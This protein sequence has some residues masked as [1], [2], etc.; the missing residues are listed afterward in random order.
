MFVEAVRMHLDSLPAEQTGWLAGLRDRYVGRALTLCTG[1]RRILGRSR[2]WRARSGCHARHSP[3]ASCT[4]RPPPDALPYAVAHAGSGRTA[5]KSRREYRGHCARGWLWVGGR[6]QPRLQEDG[7]HAARGLAPTAR[8][9][10]SARN[11][12]PRHRFER[13]RRRFWPNPA[14]PYSATLRQQSRVKLPWC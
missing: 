4:R 5:G 13:A 2:S 6:L 12:P 9:T 8:L 7:R 1:I 3:I 10:R 11:W 14:K